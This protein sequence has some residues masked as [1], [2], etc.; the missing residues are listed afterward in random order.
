MKLSNQWTVSLIFSFLLSVGFASIIT[1]KPQELQITREEVADV[2]PDTPGDQPGTVVTI[3][4]VS[5]D[6]EALSSDDFDISGWAY[7]RFEQVNKSTFKVY[8]GT[9][10]PSSEDSSNTQSPPSTQS[11][12]D[13]GATGQQA[14]DDG[15]TGQQAQGTAALAATTQQRTPRAAS[16]R[17]VSG[18]SQ[19]TRRGDPPVPPTKQ[20]GES[21]PPVFVG[22]QEPLT[23][24][25]LDTD[26]N[27]AEGVEVTF[28]R[29]SE[30]ANI[31]EPQTQRALSNSSGLATAYFTSTEPGTFLVEATAGGLPPVLFTLTASLPPTRLVK[32]SGHNQKGL[33]G[34]PLKEAF[35]VEVIDKNGDPVSG[36]SVTFAVIAGGGMLSATSTMTDSEGRTETLLTTGNTWEINKIQGIVLGVNRVEF[37]ARAEPEVLLEKANRPVMYW[38][39]NGRLYRLEGVKL[40][41]IADAV[42][43][44]A[45]GSGK[46]Y[47]TSQTSSDTGTINRANF[48]GSG[49]T[50]LASIWSVPREIMVDPTADKLYWT[51]SRG[52]I[53]EAY[54]DG[55]GIRNVVKDLS[56]PRHI[57]LRNDYIYWTE[58]GERIRRVNVTG[59]KVIEDVATGLGSVGGLAVG[60]EKLYWTKK[61]GASSGTINSANL[62][63]S[64]A[65]VFTS[66]RGVPQ[67]IAVDAVGGKLYWTDSLGRV[68]RSALDPS[69]IRTVVKGLISPISLVIGGENV[70]TATPMA[71]TNAGPIGKSAPAETR[72]LSNYPNPFNPET[73]IPYHLS[74]DGDVQISIYDAQGRLVRVLPLG[75]QSAGSYTSRSRA[76]YWDGRNALGERVASGVYFYTFTVGEF[77]ATRKMLIRK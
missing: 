72:L 3:S 76:G 7:S 18:N 70:V 19:N 60:A 55:S 38:I 36:V 6:P 45:I 34:K 71:P 4:I 28:N 52:R 67:G 68:R 74:H 25:V 75:Y 69:R 77:T 66:I 15:T 17:A 50:V 44:I 64:G 33:P 21:Q 65:T 53:Q 59:Q 20:T 10:D 8:L 16:L 63:G 46:L 23:V 48:D 5:D 13:D 30:D 27:P 24:E 22:R 26:K 37:W 32:V 51:N 49:V 43:G 57:T 54:L 12:D 61:M 14:H 56:D 73:W 42:E 29:V 58:G 41:K 62:D 1:A 31:A 40:E 2:D 35:V 47:W 39:D 9:H 11:S